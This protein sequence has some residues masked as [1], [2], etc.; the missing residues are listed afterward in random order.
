MLH[1]KAATCKPELTIKSYSD[2]TD[3]RIDTD[4][5]RATFLVKLTLKGLLLK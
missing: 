3:E 1:G 2:N 5:S 4:L